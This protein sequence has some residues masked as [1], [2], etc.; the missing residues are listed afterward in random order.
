MSKPVGIEN[1]DDSKRFG[2]VF[3]TIVQLVFQQAG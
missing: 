2:E 3:Q 1:A